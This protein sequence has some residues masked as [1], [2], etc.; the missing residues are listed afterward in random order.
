MN[1]KKLTVVTLSGL[2]LL[3]GMCACT[4]KQSGTLVVDGDETSV[5]NPM[6]IVTEEEMCQETGIDLPKKDGMENVEYAVIAG[7]VAQMT[8]TYKGT[9]YC[10]RAQST[11]ETSI[12]TACVEIDNLSGMHYEWDEAGQDT[13]QNRPGIVSKTKDGVAMVGWL[14]VVPGIEYTLTCNEN[15]DNI[16]EVANAVFTPLQGEA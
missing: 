14:D 2:M 6:K 9:E 11:Q 5:V 16:L 15:G 1:L 10:L 8:F 4:K 13:V 3:G 7:K 12:E